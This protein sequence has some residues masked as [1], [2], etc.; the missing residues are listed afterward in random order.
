VVVAAVD[1]EHSFFETGCTPPLPPSRGL[2]LGVACL[3]LGFRGDGLAWRDIV[4][5]PSRLVAFFS[6]LPDTLDDLGDIWILTSID[7]RTRLFVGV[8]VTFIMAMMV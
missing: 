1:S 7:P 6:G 5:V 2:F 3:E 4:A 8:T